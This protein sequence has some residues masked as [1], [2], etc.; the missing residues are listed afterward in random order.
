MSSTPEKR[1]RI[2]YTEG[3]ELPTDFH[4]EDDPPI[5]V[6]VRP[7]KR[8]RMI[9]RPVPG[10]LELLLPKHLSLRDPAV[11]QFIHEAAEQL[12][13]YIPQLPPER[14]SRER[15][16]ELIENWSVIMKVPPFRTRFQD[17]R[18]R[19]GSCT[20]RRT[21]TYSTRLTWLPEPLA[22]YIIVHELA[23]LE[24]M[25]HDAP[26]W[27]LVEQY[28]P[29]YRQREADLRQFEQQIWGGTAEGE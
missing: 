27:A 22:E 5:A 2:R 16:N 7:Q 12:L 9:M 23:H 6:H 15:L 11:Q 8:R 13:P 14:T 1:P 21:I 26:F 24:Q 25:N 19:W 3:P 4:D 17:M 28:M 29:D 10:G 20:G 18:R